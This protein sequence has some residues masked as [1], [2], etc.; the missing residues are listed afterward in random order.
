[1]I[2]LTDISKQFGAQNLFEDV[3]LQLDPGN[4]YGLVGANG[5]GKSTLLRIITGEEEASSGTV[6]MPRNLTLGVLK[7]DHFEYE[8][9][10]IL[11]V[12]MMG[13]QGLWQAMEEKERVLAAE[14]FDADRYGDLEDFIL[15]HDGYGFEARCAEILEGLG[16]STTKHRQTLSTL[17]GGFKFRVLLAQTL[18][19]SPGCLLLDEPTNHL[20]ILSIRW[21][22]TF[23][24][25][26]PGCALVISHD[27][28][29]LN[30]VCSHILDVDYRT[31][32]AYTGNYRAFETAKVSNRNRK[33]AEISKREKQ[34][35]QHKAFA[36]RFRAKATK[37]RQAQSKLKAIERIDLEELP[38][39]SRR[40]PKFGFTQ[41]RPS[42]KTV[43]EIEGLNKAYGDNHVLKDVDLMIR[44]GDR[45]A[46][47]GPNGI[48]K[49]TLLKILM[50]VIPADSGEVLWGHETH[51]GYFAQDH[52]DIFG[53]RKGTVEGFLGEAAAGRDTGWVRGRLGRV[54][55][56]KEEV[57]KK[58]GAL[59]GGEATRLIFARL[60]VDE[61]NVLVLD[62]PTNHLDLEAIEALV[63]ALE[64]YDGT[65]ILVSHDRWFVSRIA[66]R[67]L[68]LTP[69]DINDFRGSYE[70]Y[71]ERCGDDHLDSRAVLQKAREEKRRKKNRKGDTRDQAPD[72]EKQRLK[73]R[74]DLQLRLG[75][76][77]LAIEEAEKKIAALDTL[78]C[79]PDFF[80]DRDDKEVRK[81]GN[82]RET[83]KSDI[84]RLNEEWEALGGELETLG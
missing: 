41:R 54:L 30:T 7:Q 13:H 40:H 75:V 27:H 33:E 3:S 19:S 42:G 72:D 21:L 48:G 77:E 56:S 68:E 32:T 84:E 2:T 61:P 47:I 4:R 25:D 10:P 69:E 16:I 58:L 76:V 78:F 52:K 22:E 34:I 31:I 51:P 64:A 24:V 15:T 63:Q 65:I 50:K 9:T 8:N 5:S 45:L 79:R 74:K 44:R 38:P 39:S 23:L 36:D 14:P 43:L 73:R 67:I 11:E 62:E 49:S 66:N 53:D 82:E 83:L 12:A 60:S 81:L 6:A 59:S 17:S 37:A 28:R 55:F 26:Y 71:L 46:I 57:E 35:A 20:D 29:F 18:A 80:E 1:M 70:E